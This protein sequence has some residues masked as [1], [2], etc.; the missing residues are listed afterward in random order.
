MCDYSLHSVASRPAT[1]GDRLVT[2]RFVATTT[3]G[4]A[5]VGEPA[6]AVCLL[7]GTEIAFEREVD[8]KPAFGIFRRRNTHYGKVARFRQINTSDQ[9][10]HHDAVEFPDGKVVLLTQLCEGQ[11]AMV[12]QLPASS[13]AVQQRQ[14]QSFSHTIDLVPNR[15]VQ[16]HET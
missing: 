16:A 4:F 9:N 15:V 8:W 7:P 13:Q 3:R 1:A 14:A 5:A 2:T 6:V 10:C 11:K 12:L